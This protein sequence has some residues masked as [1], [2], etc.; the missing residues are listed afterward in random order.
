MSRQRER[1]EMEFAEGGALA[2]ERLAAAEFDVLVTDIRMPGVD[3]VEVLRFAREASPGTTRLVLSGD[4]GL[5]AAEPVFATAHRCLSKPCSSAVLTATLERVSALRAS[6]DDWALRRMIGNIVALPP[7]PGVYEELLAAVESERAT[8]QELAAI[9]QKD[10]AIATRVLR[11]ADMCTFSPAER[12]W[13]IDDAVGR[14]GAA[15]IGQLVRDMTP[16]DSASPVAAVFEVVHGHSLL[17]AR[18]ASELVGDRAQRAEAFIA[19]LVHDAGALALAAYFPERFRAM[20][21]ESR[22]SGEPLHEVE[23][24]EFAVCHATLGAYLLGLWG[25]PDSVVDA[26]AAH[27]APAPFRQASL[28][29][30]GA[31]Q[32]ADRLAHEV[33]DSLAP[34]EGLDDSFLEHLDAP[35]Q[36]TAWR[37]RAS[38]LGAAE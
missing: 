6:V 10:I 20:L 27:H 19:G 13:S 5:R 12:F 3:G 25:L 24:R 7:L 38:E 31:L 28:E 17:V 29:V 4:A 18:L 33:R 21:V 14:L 22:R 23:A 36:V 11:A 1:W 15:S 30:A 16:V 26:V 9:V 34:S 37:E 8:V 35:D 32:V 2:K